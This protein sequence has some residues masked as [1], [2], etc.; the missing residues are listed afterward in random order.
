MV[1]FLE[2]GGEA[3]GQLAVEAD[4]PRPA[5]ARDQYIAVA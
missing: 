5:F 3:V 1:P 4:G 2:E